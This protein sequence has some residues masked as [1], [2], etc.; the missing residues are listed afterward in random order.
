MKKDQSK[1][2]FILL[3]LL[4]FTGLTLVWYRFD[5]NL[6]NLLLIL[7]LVLS[8][9][10]LYDFRE[11]LAVKAVLSETKYVVETYDYVN[12][13]NLLLLTPLY[14]FDEIDGQANYSNFQ[15]ATTI[16]LVLIITV[17]HLRTSLK[18]F[19][20][21]DET[22]IHELDGTLMIDSGK[23]E[24]IEFSKWE[25]TIHTKDKPNDL[26]IKRYRLASPDWE[27]LQTIV[28][29]KLNPRVD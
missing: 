20:Y 1:Y 3:L 8:I 9:K 28:R 16:T 26:M 14:F 17:I 29:Q 18:S 11:K 7:M 6:V 12:S 22:G 24:E 19:H 25:I 4:I 2:P 21:I 23:I 5:G 27:T 13:L 10:S 15:I